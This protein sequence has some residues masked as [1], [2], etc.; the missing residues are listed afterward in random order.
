MVPAL[1]SK[2]PE[3]KKNKKT[4]NGYIWCVCADVVERV[5]TFD[6]NSVLFSKKIN[7]KIKERSSYWYVTIVA[8]Q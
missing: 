6:L 3:K 4:E 1:G 7:K 5:F 8:N 2:W